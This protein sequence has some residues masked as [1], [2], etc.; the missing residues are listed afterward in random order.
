MHRLTQI[1]RT[2]LFR[3]LLVALV[4]L[5]ALPATPA[6]A[7]DAPPTDEAGRIGAA[8]LARDG[9]V[10]AEAEARLLE[11]LQRAGNPASLLRRVLDATRNWADAEARL[12]DAWVVQAGSADPDTRERAIRLIHALGPQGVSRLASEL[13]FARLAAAAESAESDPATEPADRAPAS[14]P[15]P[16]PPTPPEPPAEPHVPRI[17]DAR[18]RLEAR[19]LGPLEIR[20]FLVEHA[21]ASQVKEVGGRYVVLADE[22]GHAALK[23]ALETPPTPPAQ[24]AVQPQVPPAPATGDAIGEVGGVP[25]PAAPIRR[26][27]PP[28]GAPVSPP[29]SNSVAAPVRTEREGSDTPASA[30][31]PGEQATS[32]GAEKTSTGPRWRLRAWVVSV[33]QQ[34]ARGIFE[35]RVSSNRGVVAPLF[36]EGKGTSAQVRVGSLADANQWSRHA[37]MLPDAKVFEAPALGST[38]SGP[39][40][41][42]LGEAV[43]YR[44][45]VVAGDGGSWRVV[46]GTVDAGLRIEVESAHGRGLPYLRLAAEFLDAPRPF[47]QRTVRP[48]GAPQPF[49]LDLPEPSRARATAETRIPHD[50]AG[51]LFLFSDLQPGHHVLV[52]LTARA[53]D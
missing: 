53:E 38:G 35:A 37:Q 23:K 31:E 2:P 44:E 20:A 34:E 28:V 50:G 33:P 18:A 16:T 49:T 10:R 21:N 1:R 36:P 5:F 46:Q 14:P 19:G 4:A 3:G 26:A 11:L 24:P 22:A 40:S 9:A 13:R 43:P 48:T 42:F 6:H 17:Y 51:A 15:P 52:V 25:P 45:D 7:D 12:L 29:P 39:I 30:A 27:G 32:G 8:L 47:Q 41:A